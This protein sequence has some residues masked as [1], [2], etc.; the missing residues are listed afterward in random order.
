MSEVLTSNE[1]Q[2]AVAPAAPAA[3]APPLTPESETEALQNLLK[4]KIAELEQA[5][6]AANLRQAVAETSKPTTAT[7]GNAMQDVRQ[8]RAIR[9]VGGNAK[10]YSMTPEQRLAA[11]G[12]RPPTPEELKLV[13]RYFGPQSSAMEA[14]ALAKQNP[15]QYRRLR[16]VAKHAGIF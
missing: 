15:D 14:N 2:A 8:E 11:V 12:E 7:L 4:T 5:I 13:T 1:L 6:E 10:Y 9:A 16:V 3:P